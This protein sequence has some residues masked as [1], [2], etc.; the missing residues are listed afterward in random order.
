MTDIIDGTSNTIFFAE[1]TTVCVR[2]NL[3]NPSSQRNYYN[4]WS[5]GRGYGNL[6]DPTFASLIRGPGSK[7]L[8]APIISGPNANCDPRLASA[9]R[10][11]GILVGL[12]D[13][14]VRLLSSSISPD[15]WWHACTPNGG[16]LLGEDW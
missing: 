5:Y 1:K 2:P 12:G 3:S 7:F 4:I 8:S 13:G 15:V 16:E 14:S 6:Y 11:A 9:P 10:S